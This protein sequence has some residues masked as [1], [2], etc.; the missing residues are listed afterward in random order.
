M[1]AGGRAPRLPVLIVTDSGG[2]DAFIRPFLLRLPMNLPISRRQLPSVTSG[3][4][5]RAGKGRLSVAR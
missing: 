3:E 5:T 4:T 2:A 1:S